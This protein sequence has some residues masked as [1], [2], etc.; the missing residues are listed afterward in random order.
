LQ[1]DPFDISEITK[2]M[3]KLLT[4]DNLRNK[5][6]IDG[7]EWVKRFSWEKAIKET[8]SVYEQA[9]DMMHETNS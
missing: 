6:I 5:S 7:K 4:D 8:L 9:I 1:V 2:G 3:L